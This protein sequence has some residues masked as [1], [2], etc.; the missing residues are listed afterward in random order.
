VSTQIEALRSVGIFRGLPDEELE[1]I[2]AMCSKVSFEPGNLL[3]EAGYPGS[4]AFVILEGRV[5]V[6]ARGVDTE[7]GAGEVVGE[8]AL[9]RS[10]SKRIAR[11][12]AITHVECLA[13]DRAAFRSLISSDVHLA[14]ALLEN[15]AN[16]VP[17]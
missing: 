17:D 14:I 3:I 12:Q 7:L 5:A 9:L 16:R 6:H 1:R 13:I 2:A 11:V 8:L 15:L 10:D 4:G